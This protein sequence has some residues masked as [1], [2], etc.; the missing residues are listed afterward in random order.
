MDRMARN[1]PRGDRA[2]EGAQNW[3]RFWRVLLESRKERNHEPAP[4]S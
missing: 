2:R 4:G 3:P 1:G